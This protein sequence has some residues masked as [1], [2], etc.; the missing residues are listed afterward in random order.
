[1]TASVPRVSESRT[2][3]RAP[4][5][6]WQSR[7]TAASTVELEDRDATIQWHHDRDL[8]AACGASVTVSFVIIMTRMR[9]STPRIRVIVIMITTM[10]MLMMT[11]VATVLDSEN[12]QNLL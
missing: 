12:W 3:R 8:E 11:L 2:R 10:I 6:Q 5:D 7:C 9:A 4:V 1:V